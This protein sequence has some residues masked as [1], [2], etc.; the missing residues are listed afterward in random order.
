MGGAERISETKNAQLKIKRLRVE[1]SQNGL[2]LPD[3]GNRKTTSPL[4][5]NFNTSHFTSEGGLQELTHACHLVEIRDS[6]LSSR[7]PP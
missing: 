6:R 4:K 1:T 5:K 7:K 3:D 2:E